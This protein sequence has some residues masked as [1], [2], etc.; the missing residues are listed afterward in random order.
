MACAG[1]ATAEY[2]A[3]VVLVALTFLAL[4]AWLP[5]HADVP[6]HAALELPRPPA[7]APSGRIEPIWRSFAFRWPQDRSPSGLRRWFARASTPVRSALLGVVFASAAVEE[8]GGQARDLVQDPVGWIRDRTGRPGLDELGAVDDGVRG[9][10]GWVREIRRLGYRRGS[11][12]VA[13]D[14]GH[15]GGRVVVEWVA[16]G[17]TLRGVLRRPQRR[18]PPVTPPARGRDASATGGAPPA[19]HAP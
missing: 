9:L 10:P 8:I 14:L 5:R 1:Q 13:H 11:E 16:R 7:A 6:R 17:R 3:L 4:A 19:R 12:R 18:P 2:A 15:L